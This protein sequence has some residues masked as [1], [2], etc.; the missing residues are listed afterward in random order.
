MGL[1]AA[2]GD[3]RSWLLIKHRDDWAGDVDIVEFAPLSVKSG[4][5]FEDILA[6][7]TPGC[8]GIQPTRQRRRG[9]RDAGEDHRAR[10]GAEGWGTPSG[11]ESPGGIEA[12]PYPV[13]KKK[14]PA[15]AAKRRA[16]STTKAPV[17]RLSSWLL[18]LTTS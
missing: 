6:A 9:R 5:D 11:E 10:N 16:R 18:A 2:A 14:K 1:G 12:G 3:A 13:T 4:G 17:W 8:L 7:D 15:P